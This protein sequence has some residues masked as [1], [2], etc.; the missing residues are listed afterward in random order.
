MGSNCGRCL[1]EL[2]VDKSDNGVKR[3]PGVWVVFHDVFRDIVQVLQCAQLLPN[4]LVVLLGWLL[5]HLPTAHTPLPSQ[6]V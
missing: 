5:K 4:V 1:R 3:A 6:H 2:A